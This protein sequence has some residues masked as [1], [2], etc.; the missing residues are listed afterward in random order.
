MK[1]DCIGKPPLGR[2]R[3]AAWL[4]L[5]ATLGGGLAGALGHAAANVMIWDTGTPLTSAGDLEHRAG[6][7]VVP[8]NLF[9]L[10]ADP[11]KAASDPGYYGREYAFAGDA[12]VEN[13]RVAAVFASAQGRVAIYVKSAAPPADGSLAPNSSLGQKVIEFAPGISESGSTTLRRCQVL[14]NADDEAALQ[15]TF[16]GAASPETTA[17]FAFDRTEIVEVRPGASLKRVSVVGPLAYGIVPSFI[18]DD[19][20][21]SAADYPSAHALWIPAE[22]VVLGLVPGEETAVVMTWPGGAARTQLRLSATPTGDRRIE[23]IDVDNP[24]Q[25]FYLAPL[26]APGL[27][28]RETLAPSYLERDVKS[29]WRRP[30]PAKWKTQL[31]EGTVKTTYTF[32]LTKSEVWRGVPGSYEYPVWFEGAEAF[33]HLGKKVPPR[34]ESVIYCLEGQETPSAITTPVDLMK[35]TLGR[36]MCEPILDDAGRQLRTHHRRGGAGV[37]RACT[38]GCTEAIQ[39]VFEAGAESAQKGKI[40]GEVDD[41]RFF[42]QQHMARIGEYRQFADD[43]SRFL[44]A[45]GQTAPELKPYL[46][47]LEQIARQ[48]PQA[49]DVQK[50]NMKSLSYADE[51]ARQTLALTESQGTNH[52]SAYMDLLKAWRDMGGAQD[53]LVALCHTTTRALCQE[54]GYACVDQPKAAELACAIRARCRQCLR[55]P[56]GYEIWPDY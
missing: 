37:H 55:H 26:R 32:R 10:E 29:Q 46:D 7:K 20:I 38:C 5:L 43:M 28:H 42:I 6:W 2:W 23:S 53:Y 12:V 51:L 47:K 48:I 8:S 19:L 50:E 39:A 31:Y 17:V 45:Q 56:D 4:V 36:T 21:Y 41:M 11:A 13:Q 1:A 34:G 40:A 33:F 24:G 22:N 18:G 44:Q 30:F 27:W 15:V 3:A 16:A 25:S 52:L 35:A 49:Y 14:R 9:T 54:A